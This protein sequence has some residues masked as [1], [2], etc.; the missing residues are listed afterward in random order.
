MRPEE[1]AASE[2][3]EDCL[4]HSEHLV[5]KRFLYRYANK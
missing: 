5:Y 2:E 4:F 3:V 1:I